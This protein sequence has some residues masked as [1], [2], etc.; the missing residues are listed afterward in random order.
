MTSNAYRRVYP[1]ASRHYLVELFTWYADT[2]QRMGWT[3]AGMREALSLVG[4]LAIGWLLIIAVAMVTARAVRRG[5]RVA[6][7]RLPGQAPAT[8]VLPRWLP[9]YVGLSGIIA[10]A[11]LVAALIRPDAMP[12]DESTNLFWPTLAG[13][14][15]ISVLWPVLL[16]G[17]MLFYLLGEGPR[18]WR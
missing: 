5:V 1:R 17:I 6:L 11:T 13:F 10:T 8:T 2:T 12:V 4:A 3:V 16:F 18:P 14:I 15:F 7:L 9:G